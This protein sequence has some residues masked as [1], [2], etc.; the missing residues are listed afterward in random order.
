VSSSQMKMV[1]RSARSAKAVSIFW[2]KWS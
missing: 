2:P 1:V